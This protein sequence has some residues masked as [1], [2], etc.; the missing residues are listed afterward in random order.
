MVYHLKPPNFRLIIPAV[1][2]A[3]GLCLRTVY[4]WD[5]PLNLDE[6]GHM[7]VI[8][9]LGNP[10]SGWLCFL[11]SRL[12]S[13]PLFSDYL[14][15]MGMVVSNGNL[16]FVREI[17]ISVSL[18]GLLGIY[19][20]TRRLFGERAAVI[21]LGLAAV[22]RYMV[23][24]SPLLVEQAGYAATPWILYLFYRAVEDGHAR[25]YLWLGATSGVAY[26][27]YEPTL[28]I[29]IP[30]ALYCLIFGKLKGILRTPALWA[31]AGLFM[32]II[33][34]HLIW[35]AL[36]DWAN[37]QRHASLAGGLGLSPRVLLLYLGDIF[38][39]EA[40]P[41]WLALDSGNTVYAPFRI[42][43]HALA[44]A[45]YLSG[46]IL[47]LRQYRRRPY[48]LLLL[49]FFATALVVSLINAHESWNNFWWATPCL[50]T[51]IILAAALLGRITHNS[52]VS[53]IGLLLFITIPTL[54]FLT[55]DKLGYPDYDTE[56]NH[57]GRMLVHRMTQAGG[58]G[59][60]AAIMK[61]EAQ[62][63]VAEHP[64]SSLGH[65]YLAEAYAGTPDLAETH[66]A[67]ASRLNPANPLAA[68]NKAE[69]YMTAGNWQ[70]A[71]STLDR[72]TESGRDYYVIRK[73]LALASYKAGR[74]S[75]AEIHALE[76]LHK[77]PDARDLL[78]LLFL[79]HNKSGNSAKADYF[80]EAYIKATYDF[81]W[82][83]YLDIAHVLMEEGDKA[84][85]LVYM[86]KAR[87]LHPANRR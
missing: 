34:P 9:S 29:A 52:K 87:A 50:V 35:N 12:T 8:G 45:V 60:A 75:R 40:D 66:L 21:A 23:A 86:E 17:Y 51:S 32:L 31:G 48:N 27:F 63:F 43:C 24:W 37:F 41:F 64:G 2:M 73:K 33:F 19:V 49:I 7:Q 53:A 28:L 65:Y 42:P 36:N 54:I 20:L 56:V 81:A 46:V 82:R 58:G 25:S 79:I 14:T 74:L 71:I 30:L 77:K 69:K 55:G 18:A 11:G 10:A 72:V 62:I 5:L 47:C 22:D 61:A 67:T 57:T 13:H 70:D 84:Q 6:Q 80:L 3:V 15:G 16:L 38:I 83:G 68:N 4:A 59:M 76:A 1:L 78:A 26:M 44:S 85:A 39:S